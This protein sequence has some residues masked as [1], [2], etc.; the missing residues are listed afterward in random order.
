MLEPLPIIEVSG[1]YKSFISNDSSVLPVLNSLNFQI[2]SGSIFGLIGPSG[3]GKTTLLRIMCGLVESTNGEVFV[4]GEKIRGPTSHAVMVFQDY[5]KSLFPWKTVEGNIRFGLHGIALTEEEASEKINGVLRLVG[6]SDFA[7]EYPWRLSGGMQQRVAL[8]RALVRKPSVLL[9]DEPFGSLDAQT[10]YNLEDDVLTL[11]KQLNITI[12][13]VTHDIDEAVYM[14][15]HVAVLS[16]RPAELID[17]KAIDFAW[18]RDQVLT[19][20][21]LRFGELRGELMKLILEEEAHR[22]DVG[23][24]QTDRGVRSP[25][26]PQ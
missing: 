11:A 10:R 9:M 18:P 7:R 25:T 26:G 6:L 19:R 3:C 4:H 12:V 22:E 17:I 16:R 1:L 24:R 13:F 5:T 15:D 21:H 2:T 20:S 14:S 23:A 8:A